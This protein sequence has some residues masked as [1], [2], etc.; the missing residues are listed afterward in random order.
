MQSMVDAAV[1]LLGVRSPDSVTVRDIAERSGHHHRFVAGWFGSKAGLF[2]VAFDQMA[3]RVADDFVL[4]APRPGGGPRTPV[5]R[6]LHLMSWLAT[7]DPE[8]LQ[9][10]RA[11]PLI[12]RV[13]ASYQEQFGMT[14]DVARVSA[15]RLA[16]YL[17]VTV[18][19][20]GPL[21]VQPGDFDAH[22]ELEARFVQALGSMP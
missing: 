15:Q 13:S 11:T 6:L 3:A 5:V 4:E 20:P 2:R 17:L 14:A 18:L 19:F 16:G 7:N 1:E 22:L 9:G 21:G 10:D 8:S 12:D